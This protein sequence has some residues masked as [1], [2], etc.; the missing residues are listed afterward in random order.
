V[1]GPRPGRASSRRLAAALAER[2]GEVLPPPLVVRV[3]GP[4]L[5]QVNLY[6]D[7]MNQGGSAAAKIVEEDDGHTLAEAVETVVA[8]VL[9]GVQDA[10]AEYLALPWPTDAA[11]ELAWPGARTDGERVHL[12][13]GGSEAAAVLTLRPIAF[14]EF[15]QG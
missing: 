4:G 2:I 10:V 1:S 14:A 15:A 7:G 12:W 8:A 6:A 11:G 3:E 5:N 13:F 9:N